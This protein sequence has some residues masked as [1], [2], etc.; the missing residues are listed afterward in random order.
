MV[1]LNA[2]AW[3][4]LDA[5]AID[6]LAQLHAELALRG[7]AFC[8]ARLKDASV[9]SSR[10]RV[11]LRLSGATVSSPLSGLPSRPSRRVGRNYTP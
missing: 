10:R 6:V 11:S 2:E 1:V 4:Y 3:T 7:N 8:I 9:R 5:T